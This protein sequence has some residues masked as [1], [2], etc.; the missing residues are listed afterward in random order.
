[1]A[2]RTIG[3]NEDFKDRC[4]YLIAKPDA[5]EEL[6]LT[7][8]SSPSEARLPSHCGKEIFPPSLTDRIVFRELN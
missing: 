4:E 1:M 5:G 6:Q 2:S 8:A 7:L 3:A